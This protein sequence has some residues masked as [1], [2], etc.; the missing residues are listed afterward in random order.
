MHKDSRGGGLRGSCGWGLRSNFG[1]PFLYV[2][3]FF[4]GLIV[5]SNTKGLGTLSAHPLKHDIQKTSY[6]TSSP[7]LGTHIALRESI[8]ALRALLRR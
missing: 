7:I 4:G 2:Y 8:P 6:Q 1:A 3:V 5:G